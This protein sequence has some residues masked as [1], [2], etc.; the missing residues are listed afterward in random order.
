MGECC[1][2]LGQPIPRWYAPP[3]QSPYNPI[4]RWWGLLAWPWNG[5]K[6]V[7]RETLGAW[8]KSM[9][10]TG[11]PPLVALSRQVYQKAVTRSK[12]ARREG[13]A[14]LERHPAWPKWDILIHPAST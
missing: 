14:R 11:M 12:K 6:V 8:A 7:A 2:A 5:T 4:E 13:E 1:D 10:W 3:S 9:T